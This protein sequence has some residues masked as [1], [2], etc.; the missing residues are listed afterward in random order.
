MMMVL[1]ED[2]GIICISKRIIDY[3][4][5]RLGNLERLHDESDM[6][7]KRSVAKQHMIVVFKLESFVSNP[8]IPKG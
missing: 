5:S 6:I 1:R 7:P 8:Q 2:S 4:L 3:I